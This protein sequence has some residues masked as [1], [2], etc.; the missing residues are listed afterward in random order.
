RRLWREPPALCLGQDGGL[1]SQH[2][3]LP[4]DRS[5]L[6]RPA[7]RLARFPPRRADGTSA[8]LGRRA[9][10]DRAATDRQGR[11]SG[12]VARAVSHFFGLHRSQLAGAA[13]IAQSGGIVL[14]RP[15]AM[16]ICAVIPAA[17]RGSRLGTNRPKILAQLNARQTIW[18]VLRDKL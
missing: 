5:D 16:K 7:D 1:L 17:G 8:C 12:G 4:A 6:F 15:L 18:S 11:G 2:A 9:P 10:G 14:M 13:R 3:V